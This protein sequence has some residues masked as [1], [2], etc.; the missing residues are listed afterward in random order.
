MKSR[1]FAVFHVRIDFIFS[2]IENQKTARGK[3]D[4]IIHPAVIG[5]IDLTKPLGDF[6]AKIMVPSGD[7]AGALPFCDFIGDPQRQQRFFHIVAAGRDIAVQDQKVKVAVKIR[8]RLNCSF[9][10]PMHV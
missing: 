4:G 1:S 2:A 10:Q 5:G 7:N 8:A 6:P 3:M 9:S